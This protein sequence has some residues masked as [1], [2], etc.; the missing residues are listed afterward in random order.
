M[1]TQAGAAAPCQDHTQGSLYG[2][3]PFLQ[4]YSAQGHTAGSS[5]FGTSVHMVSRSPALRPPT[6]VDLSPSLSLKK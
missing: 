6:Q 4:D 1:W 5:Q 3:Y 2:Q